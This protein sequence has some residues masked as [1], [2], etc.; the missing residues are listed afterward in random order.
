MK[1]IYSFKTQLAALICLLMLVCPRANAKWELLK[2]LDA[3]QAVHITKGGVMLLSDYNYD[4]KGGIYYSTDKGA[5]WTKCGIADYNYNKYFETD[6]YV[7]ALGYAGRIARS[8]DEGKTW[9]LLNYTLP[10]KGILSNDDIEY[11]ACYAMALYHGKLFVGDFSG[12]GVLYSEDMGETWNLTDR[13]SLSI[14]VPDAKAEE[15]VEA[16][17]NLMTFN[18]ELYAFGT[19]CVYKYEE[20]TNTWLRI[21]YDSNF[22]AVATI[23]KGKM[24]CGRSCPS[25]T[26]DVAFLEWT[27][28][29]VD[30][31]W[32][33]R[34]DECSIVPPEKDF[35]D[36][37]VR[38]MT[39]DENNL[40]VALQTRGIYFST[41]EGD[42]WT[43]ISD[44]LPYI[45]QIQQ[46]LSP[47]IMVTDDEYVYVAVFDH[48]FSPNKIYSGLYR[49]AKKDLPTEETGI[50]NPMTQQSGHIYADE[51]SLHFDG[52]AAVKV[53]D[54]AGKQQ[55]VSVQPGRAD[56]SRLAKG[57]YVYEL[58]TADGKKVT[59]KFMK[60]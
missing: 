40:Y 51:S 2:Q 6:E 12:G 20:A 39:H 35:Y 53:T 31:G 47:L 30:W 48:M 41:N 54:V 24:Y 36:N 15:S 57:V 8:D 49:W 60:K 32:S 3:A 14:T 17:Y 37:N 16:I 38:A 13:E 52:E 9:E 43:E 29:G 22:M 50:D 21:R 34:P 19:Y 1:K 33:G 42:S 23:F 10:L 4:R 28:N 18:D 7:F 27:E 55:S 58:T 45:E 26:K 5:T 46:Y 44:G 11:T 59:G 25:E 56:I